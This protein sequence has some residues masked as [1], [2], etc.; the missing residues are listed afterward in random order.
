MANENHYP[1]ICGECER[2]VAYVAKSRDEYEK[3]VREISTP[4]DIIE[5]N[6]LCEEC[7]SFIKEEKV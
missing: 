3:I 7:W 4:S 5:I 2:Q 6:Y 1:I